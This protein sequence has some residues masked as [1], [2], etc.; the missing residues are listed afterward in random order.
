[1]SLSTSPRR[2]NKRVKREIVSPLKARN[3]AGGDVLLRPG[4]VIEGFR[5]VRSAELDAEPYAAHFLSELR[6]LSCPLHAF[7]PRTCFVQ[8]AEEILA[9]VVATA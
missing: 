8:G 7:L 3:V 1:V 6:E 2:A 5:I 9:R 4:T